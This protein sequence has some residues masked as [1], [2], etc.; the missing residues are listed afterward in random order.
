MIDRS[1]LQ[2]EQL[3]VLQSGL[4]GSQT[5]MGVLFSDQLS[6]CIGDCR[7]RVQGFLRDKKEQKLGDNC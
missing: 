2:A 7:L 5:V 3:D 1:D 4:F 6:I